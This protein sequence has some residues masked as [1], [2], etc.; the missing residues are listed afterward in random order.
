[1]NSFLLNLSPTKDIEIV[2]ENYGKKIHEE[3]LKMFPEIVSSQLRVSSFFGYFFEEK[4]FLNQLENYKMMI[5]LKDSNLFATIV[6]KIFRKA[7]DKER[8]FIEDNEFI[9]K[10]IIS[11]DKIW[12]GHF[13]FEDIMEMKEEE[14]SD[15]LAIKIINPIIKSD[16]EMEFIFGFNNIFYEMID[17]F[18]KFENINLYDLKEEV[19]D[20]IFVKRQKYYTKKIKL[21]SKVRNSY[22]G[23]FEI[24]ITNKEYI[25]LIHA[26]FQFSKYNG[27]GKM[28]EYGFGQ[29]L[30]K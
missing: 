26:I 7:I 12:K 4:I 11:N 22:L 16:E 5:T 2:D 9:I 24:K 6:Q 28:S 21:D 19:D 18:E 25:N 10:G 15:K 8:L 23:E 13:N 1:M 29:I 14:L 20:I 30:I 17:S 27:I 3:I